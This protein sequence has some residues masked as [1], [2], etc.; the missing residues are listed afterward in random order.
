MIKHVITYEHITFNSSCTAVLQEHNNGP[1]K[2]LCKNL[3]NF[4]QI[5]RASKRHYNSHPDTVIKLKFRIIFM[6]RPSFPG[7]TLGTPFA[8]EPQ[9][10]SPNGHSFTIPLSWQ[11]LF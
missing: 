3:G 6:T 4:L 5:L 7:L 2:K 8:Y 11:L 1:T 10:L 9:S